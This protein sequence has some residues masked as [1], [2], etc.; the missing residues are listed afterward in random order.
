M[1]R[2]ANSF[3]SRWISDRIA[4]SVAARGLSSHSRS[5]QS[6]REVS[7]ASSLYPLLKKRAATLQARNL[8]SRIV[9]LKWSIAG[10]CAWEE[11]MQ[12]SASWK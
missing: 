11:R 7:A 3:A 1:S 5:S 4:A 9:S 8:N 12:I 6:K 2:C 10:A